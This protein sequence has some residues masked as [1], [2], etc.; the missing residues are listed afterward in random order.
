MVVFG[1][2]FFVLLLLG[3]PIFLALGLPSIY[4]LAEA[5]KLSVVPSVVWGSLAKPD[6]SAVPFFI[7]M[8]HLMDQSSAVHRLFAFVKALVGHWTGGLAVATI[9]ASMFFA[10]ISGTSTGNA[11]AMTL[12]MLP[13]MTEARYDRGFAAGLIAAGGTI[14]ILIPPS[15]MFIL[16]ATITDQSVPRLF[17]AGVVPGVILGIALMLVAVFLS[18]R[19]GYGRMAPASRRERW[20]AFWR[21]LPVLLMPIVVVGGI[22][23]GFMAP[24]ES[25]VV[26]IA[27]ATALGLFYRE[28]TASRIRQALVATVK[29]TTMIYLIIATAALFA[30]VLVY[31][32][33]PQ[34]ITQ[35]VVSHI[36]S[37]FVFLLVVA[38]VLTIMGDFLDVTAILFITVPILYPIVLGLQIDPL[39][40]AAFFV[41]FMELGLIT[42]PVGLN[43]FV[44][45]GTSGMSLHEVMKGTVPFMFVIPAVALLVALVPSLATWLPSVLMP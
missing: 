25:A 4:S 7:L 13:A 36:E 16:F 1:V 34:T 35:A 39:A 38:V 23:G 31:G 27:Y 15:V 42:P 10:A 37:P 11:A 43:L 19:R 32:L 6:L 8:G 33:V 21:A 20:R 18:R 30:N 9:L 5:G 17:M 24:T 22:Y 3:A 29:S 45:A 12:M 14:G 44:V 28:L 40:F 41:M 26:G 2:T